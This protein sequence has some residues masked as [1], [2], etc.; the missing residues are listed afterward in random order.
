MAAKIDIE[1]LKGHEYRVRVREGTSETTHTV[2]VR[3]S[4]LQKIAGG[5][6]TPEDLLRVSF[7][8]LLEREPKESIM[9][10]FDLPVISGFF[11]EY[12]H[13]IRQRLQTHNGRD[14]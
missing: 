7:K 13:E 6:T 9:A 3:P 14:K 11:P 2:T 5:N 12:E 4:V 8:F 1:M 10:R